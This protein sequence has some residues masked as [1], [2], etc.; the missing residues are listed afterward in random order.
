MGWKRRT[1]H[2]KL[3]M[4]KENVGAEAKIDITE[5]T[6]KLRDHWKK[7]EIRFQF[8]QVFLCCKYQQHGF[9]RL[10]HP[11]GVDKLYCAELHSNHTLVPI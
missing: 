3:E 4:I 9:L 6:E 7:R 1:S 8:P 10:P 5:T 11:C 2:R